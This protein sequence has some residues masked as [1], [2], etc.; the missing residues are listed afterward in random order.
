MKKRRKTTKA[1]SKVD[2]RKSKS[3]KEIDVF[4]K[5]TTKIFNWAGTKKDLI[6]HAKQEFRKNTMGK[7]EDEEWE[8]INEVFKSWFILGYHTKS[9]NRL[10]RLFLDERG[11][12]LP[13]RERK[14]LKEMSVSRLLMVEVQSENPDGGLVLKEVVSG[15]TFYARK[16]E[17]ASEPLKKWDLCI[18]SLRKHDEEEII[19]YALYIPRPVYTAIVRDFEQVVE[20]LRR[21]DPSGKPEDALKK[22]MPFVLDRIIIRMR[23]MDKSHI[24]DL[25]NMLNMYPSLEPVL[26]HI[27]KSGHEDQAG[28]AAY[29]ILIYSYLDRYYNAWIDRPSNALL[30]MSPR[31]AVKES[32]SRQEVVAMV[33]DF[34][35][36]AAH[37]PKMKYDFKSLRSELGIGE[38]E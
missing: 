25:K 23:L 2:T 10:A 31:E 27:Y 37:D 3:E 9:G 6:E 11:N 14:L 35:N 13:I 8:L 33:K 15:E 21:E 34:E 17:G 20:E 4:V 18:V 1:I 28:V 5:I 26:D 38:S 29:R 12:K 7:Y 36:L 22:W 30:D 16:I 24:P 32:W 19:D